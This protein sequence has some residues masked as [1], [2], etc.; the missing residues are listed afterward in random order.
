MWWCST[1]RLIVVGICSYI[2]F[3]FIKY[4]TADEMRISDCS[5]DVCSSDRDSVPCLVGL[6][7]NAGIV[8]AVGDVECLE[9][10]LQLK[11]LRKGQHLRDARIQPVDVVHQIGRASC[12]ERVGQSV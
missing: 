11:T 10:Q 8:L 2:V 12:R 6:R 3:F 9:A 7:F 1:V 4:K 5:S